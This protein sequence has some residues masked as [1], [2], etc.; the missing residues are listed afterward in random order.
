[1]N[2]PDLAPAAAAP[3]AARLTHA[4]PWQVTPMQA[5][6]VG[7]RALFV[8]ALIALLLA[9][10]ALDDWVHLLW[11]VVLPTWG[12]FMASGL[13]LLRVWPRDRALLDAALHDTRGRGWGRHGRLHVAAL[14]RP[15]AGAAR[16]RARRHLP[17]RPSV[18]LHPVRIGRGRALQLRR[19]HPGP[20][21]P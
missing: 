9:M 4:A 1:M 8:G 21:G 3:Q 17:C 16:E 2:R 14:G 10:R 11:N 12:L 13:L 19:P 15:R 20:H 6:R 18:W 7:Y 5:L